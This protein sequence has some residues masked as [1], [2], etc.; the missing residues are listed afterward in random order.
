MKRTMIAAAASLLALGAVAYAQAPGPGPGAPGERPRMEERMRERMERRAE[1]MED[2]MDRRLERLKSNLKLT[3]QQEPLWTPVEQQLRRF[4]QERRDYRRNNFERMRDAQLPD[5]LDLMAERMAANAVSMRELSNA[6]KPLW[7]TLSD[8][9]KQAVRR[10]LPGRGAGR[11]DRR[12]E[13]GWGPHH[14]HGLHHGGER[15]G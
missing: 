2:R 4:Q 6:V 3:P 9:Q 1:R 12:G 8:E 15:R 5:R 10:A 7:A 14:G 11:E 13:G